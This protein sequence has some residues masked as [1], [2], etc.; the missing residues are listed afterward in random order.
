ME[1]ISDIRYAGYG[2]DTQPLRDLL[3]DALPQV[4]NTS[5]VG[6]L[7][8]S[9]ILYTAVAFALFSPDWETR[10]IVLRRWCFLMGWLYLFRGMTVVV[11]TLP[12][13]LMAQCTPAQAVL[14][15]TVGQRLVYMIGE[16]VGVSRMGGR[17]AVF[18][19]AAL[20]MGCDF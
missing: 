4:P 14:N 16:V 9:M 1:Q 12:S 6:T 17:F 2:R 10:F 11:T 18:Y 19:S 3:F 5:Y 8:I 20:C 7:L 13:P 15:G